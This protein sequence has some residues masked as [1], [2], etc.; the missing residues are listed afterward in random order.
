MSSEG[1][2]SDLDQGDNEANVNVLSSVRMALSFAVPPSTSA[3][4]E[5]EEVSARREH[6]ACMKP[7]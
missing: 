2:R 6:Q 4:V 7:S 3:G 1:V 5:G